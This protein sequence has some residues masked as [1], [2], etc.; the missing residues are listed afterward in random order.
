MNEEDVKARQGQAPCCR[1]GETGGADG[2]AVT[3]EAA[4][5]CPC[6]SALKEHRL[7]V[8][9]GLSLLALAFLVSQVGGILGIIGFFRTF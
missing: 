8:F 7:A 1:P 2:D 4:Q 3:A 5:A 9:G 6:G